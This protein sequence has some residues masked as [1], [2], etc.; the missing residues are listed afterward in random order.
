MSNRR[1]TV[2]GTT[3]VLDN[4]P[5]TTF[6]ADFSEDEERALIAS[7]A[8]TRFTQESSTSSESKDK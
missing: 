2:T 3:R 7:G 1:Y 6:T 8:I 5:G 4:D